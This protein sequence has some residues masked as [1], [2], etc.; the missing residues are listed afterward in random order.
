MGRKFELYDVENESDKA[1]KD[2][3][4]EEIIYIRKHEKNII[5]NAKVLYAKRKSGWCNGGSYCGI[6]Y[7]YHSNWEEV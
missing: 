5:K 6:G 3:V 4:V 2:L 1:Y 7:L